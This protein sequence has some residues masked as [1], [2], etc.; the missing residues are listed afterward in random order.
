[1]IY[2]NKLKYKYG[3]AIESKT[4]QPGFS[5]ADHLPRDWDC[6]VHVASDRSILAW[7]AVCS[8]GRWIMECGVYWRVWVYG[9]ILGVGYLLEE[10]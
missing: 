9:G 6:G 3:V 1:M 2:T 10:K 5:D 4:R 7:Y 8:S